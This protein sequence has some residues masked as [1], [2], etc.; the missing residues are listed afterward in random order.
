MNLLNWLVWALFFAAFD[1]FKGDEA[2]NEP[3]DDEQELLAR[4]IEADTAALTILY[5]RYNTRIYNFI[6]HRVGQAELAEDLTA[7]VF[8]R[9]LESIRQGR[10]WTTSFSG[11]LFRI[12]RNLVI[13]QYRRKKRGQDVELLDTLPTRALDE[14]PVHRAEQQIERAMV[15]DA[16]TQITGEQAQV[17]QLRFLEDLSIA[18]VAALMDK[19]EGAIKAMQYRAVMALR[20]V[21]MK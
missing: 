2:R 16:L 20:R 3:P 17:I 21:I 14:D 6:Y 10:G 8:T 9:M 5:D 12:A 11:W 19:T 18:E 13:D 15:R 4:A 1:V 7:Q